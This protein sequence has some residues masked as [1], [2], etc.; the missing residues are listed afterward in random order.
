MIGKDPN[1]I[2]TDLGNYLKVTAA[3]IER[4]ASKYFTPTRAT[5][6]AMEPLKLPRQ[7]RGSG[8]Q[9]DQENKQ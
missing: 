6:L 1:L 7:D 5:V 2:N 9:Q 3:D 8:Q 4:V